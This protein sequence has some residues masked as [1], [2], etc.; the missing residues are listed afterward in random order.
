MNKFIK[1]VTMV[2]MVGLLAVGAVSCTANM[3]AKS[4]GGT[5]TEQL[6]DNVKLVNITW[7]DDNLWVLTRP[8]N[9]SDKAET[10]EFKESSSFGLVNG[11]VIIKE[12]KTK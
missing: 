7:K 12:N 3:R 1:S 5:A 9:E 2:S 6:A 4:L 11:K 8:M 10:Y